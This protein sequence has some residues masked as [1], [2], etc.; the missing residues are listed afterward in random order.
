[1]LFE[2]REVSV[3]ACRFEVRTER[4]VDETAGLAPCLERDPQQLGE[5]RGHGRRLPGGGVDP[6]EL[7]PFSE[8]AERP[9]A[10]GEETLDRAKLSAGRAAH[11]DTASH[12]A[13]LVRLARHF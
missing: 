2:E 11:D 12:R 4:R 7:A 3:V 5:V 9:F 6:V 1:L 13:E 8:S 10:R